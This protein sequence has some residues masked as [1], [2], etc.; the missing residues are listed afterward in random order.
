M[1]VLCNICLAIVM[2]VGIAHTASADAALDR[3][4]GSYSGFGFAEDATGPFINTERDFELDIARVEPDGFEVS[5]STIKRKGSDPNSLEAVI[6]ND[7]AKFRPS[8][9]PGI[10]HGVSNG[11]P[12]QG[13]PLDWARLQGNMMVVYLFEVDERGVPE[14][15]VYRRML[16]PRGL[17][18]LFTASQDGKTVRTVRGRYKRR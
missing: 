17:E 15:H 2:G 9:K 12:L 13:A 3:F 14:L 8:G 10:Y 4:F 11:S 18:L 16:T 7:S 1:R 6:S 5:W